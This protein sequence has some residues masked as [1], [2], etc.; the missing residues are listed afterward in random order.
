MPPRIR[1]LLVLGVISISTVFLIPEPYADS[2]AWKPLVQWAR[3]QQWKWEYRERTIF[4][5]CG[6]RRFLFC[7][8]L[9]ELSGP[10]GQIAT[11]ILK[12]VDRLRCQKWPF[13]RAPVALPGAERPFLTCDAIVADTSIGL[14]LDF[15]GVVAYF[16]QGWPSPRPDSAHRAI[17]GR[18]EER[19]GPGQLCPHSDD[20]AITDNVRWQF[21]GSNT[22]VYLV[23]GKY[24]HLDWVYGEIHCHTL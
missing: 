8:Q 22:G 12:P 3:D 15:D 6:W 7:Q 4:V 2:A 13:T 19:N 20:L 1:Y 23:S 24:V 16:D 14:G 11:S 9:P 5:S 18:L 21:T 17:I 10:L